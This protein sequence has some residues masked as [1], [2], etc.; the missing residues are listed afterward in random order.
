MS[1]GAGRGRL[2]RQLLTES[3]LL[4]VLGAG[5]GLLVTHWGLG[6]AQSMAVAYGINVDLD[7]RVVAFTLI[8]ALACGVGLALLP[9]LRGTHVRLASA[10]TSQARGA[11]G[12]TAGRTTARV[13]VAGQIALSAFLLVIAALFARSLPLRRQRDGGQSRAASPPM[14]HEAG[15]VFSG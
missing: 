1:I 8:V 14:R 9:A 4:S 2:V 6:L 15:P 10:L 12:D 11:T 13:L 7:W 3:L 5:L